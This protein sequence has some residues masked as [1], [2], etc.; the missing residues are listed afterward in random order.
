MQLWQLKL[1]HSQFLC[2]FGPLG[3]DSDFVAGVLRTIGVTVVA[4]AALV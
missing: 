3:G 2:S 1:R 4:I